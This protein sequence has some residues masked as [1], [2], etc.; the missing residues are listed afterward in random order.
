[1][2][3]DIVNTFLTKYL[4]EKDKTFLHISH[5]LEQTL[6]LIKVVCIHAKNKLNS[7]IIIDGAFMALSSDASKVIFSIL[8]AYSKS[9]QIILFTQSSIEIA[10]S[11]LV[12]KL[13]EGRRKFHTSICYDTRYNSRS[14]I[15]PSKK[16]AEDNLND[17]GPVIVT[18]Y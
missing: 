17:E 13:P 6:K 7:P 14:L 9:T 4:N 12:A 1:M 16:S 3:N 8:S 10:N 2:W 18:V 11:Y 5:G 15:I